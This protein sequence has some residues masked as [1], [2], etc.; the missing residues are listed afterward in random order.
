MT[1]RANAVKGTYADRLSYKKIIKGE[2]EDDIGEN[3]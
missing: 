2:F 1:V 3:E